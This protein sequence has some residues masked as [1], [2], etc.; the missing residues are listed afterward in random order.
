VQLFEGRDATQPINPARAQGY[1]ILCHLSSTMFRCPPKDARVFVA[2][3]RGQEQTPGAGII[4]ASVGPTSGLTVSLQKDRAVLDFGP[5]THVA[6][7]GK[8]VAI[9]SPG[10]EFVSVGT[11]RSGGPPGVTIQAKDGSGI[12]AQ[13]GTLGLFVAQGGDAK[14]VMQF[15]PTQIQCFIKSGGYYHVDADGFF[16]TGNSCWMSGGA[17]YIGSAP[18]IVTPA[19]YGPTGIAGVASTSVFISP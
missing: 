16:C 4:F 2:I 14:A 17:N 10:G 6:I 15:T 11:P 12:V 3:A 19:L 9:T 1:K 13:E 8:S 5:D 18:T 7:C